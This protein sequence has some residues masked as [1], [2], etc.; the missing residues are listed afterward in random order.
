M[1]WL[2]RVA[3]H[4]DYVNSVDDFAKKAHFCCVW[5]LKLFFHENYGADAASRHP[6]M[7]SKLTFS[8]LLN[9][10]SR[11]TTS[12]E[13]SFQLLNFSLY[14]AEFS[15]AGSR[16]KTCAKLTLG[17]TRSDGSDRL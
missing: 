12:S 8:R 10:T 6:C 15:S 1:N 9:C 5:V 17:K 3:Q 11:N 7:V 4:F 2:L 14:F 13:K 16:M